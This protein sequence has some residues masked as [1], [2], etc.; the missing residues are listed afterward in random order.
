MKAVTLSAKWKP[1]SDFK[2][3]RKDIDG[4]LTYLGSKVWKHPELA[5]TE[6]EKPKIGE[7]DVLVEI[8]ACGICGSDVHMAEPDKE[9]YILY[10]GLT[11]FPVVLG[12]EFAGVVVEAGEKA[13][14]KRTGRPYQGGEAVCAEEML[15][16][17]RC[18]PCADGYPNHCEMLQE[19]GFSVNGAFAKYMAI[20][21]RYLWSLD[22]LKDK[23]RGDDIYLAGSL[24]EPTSVAYNAV[25]ER[26][27]GIR[28]GDNVVILGGGPI[29]LA[30]VSILKRAG[31]SH[32]ILSEPEADRA[33][34]AM[35][36]GATATVNPVKEKFVEKILDLTGG[37]GANLYL[38]A[39][40]L[41]NVVWA[42]IEQCI[43]EGR[44]LN[45]R[46]VIVARADAKIP[47]TGEVFQVRRAAI[48]GSQG[49]SGH[50]TFPRVI[51]AMAAGMDMTKI[52]TKKVKLDAVPENIVKLRTDRKECK[53]TALL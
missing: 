17:S 7:A 34:L 25:I 46:V 29:G 42:D 8:K 32:V 22:D 43:W 4:K 30:A 26:A 40:G 9:G 16:C 50:G 37:M 41:P 48:I 21:S 19:L 11:A 44:A 20:D 38:E 14:D 27:G 35:Q 31:A 6:V 2:L 39:T 13:V 12:H 10:P 18:R 33:K 53:I 3:G 36:M 45:A 5:I 52:I 49:H 47:V 24:V 15:W 23:Y 28:T 51:S 1:K